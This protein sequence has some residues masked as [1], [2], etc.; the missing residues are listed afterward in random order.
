[1]LLLHMQSHTI[2]NVFDNYR[3][4][5]LGKK[6]AT[7]NKAALFDN[8]LLFSYWQCLLLLNSNGA[9]HAWGM[10]DTDIIK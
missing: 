8:R 6:R 4:P 1:M 2:S 9:Y 7:F 10:E 5:V 3:L